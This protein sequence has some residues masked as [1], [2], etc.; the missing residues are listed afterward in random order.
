MARA[1]FG[2]DARMAAQPIVNKPI[3]IS[4][5]KGNL[6]LQNRKRAVI[7]KVARATAPFFIFLFFY[8]C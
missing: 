2:A 1:D 3:I 4:F 7:T 6:G 8:L 5:C